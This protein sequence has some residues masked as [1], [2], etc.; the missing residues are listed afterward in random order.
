MHSCNTFVILLNQAFLYAFC[1]N[2][3]KYFAKQLIF[4][5]FLEAISL[6]N[7][8][9][10]QYFHFNLSMFLAIS[11]YNVT[12]SLALFKTVLVVPFSNY[13]NLEGF[14]RGLNF[15]RTVQKSLS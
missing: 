5:F 14:S 9:F 2:R 13:L 6:N 10:L 15:F 3:G 12:I 7:R 1:E 8:L 11:Y 4:N